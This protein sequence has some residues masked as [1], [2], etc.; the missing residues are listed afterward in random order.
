[1]VVV[2]TLCCANSSRM[3]KSTGSA[4]LGA[5]PASGGFHWKKNPFTGGD[6][7]R[8]A[9]GGR[10]R[11]AE[12]GTGTSPEWPWNTARNGPGT[13]LESARNGPGTSPEPARHSP[14][15]APSAHIT[16]SAA[17]GKENSAVTTRAPGQSYLK[18]S[19]ELFTS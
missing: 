16:P 14:G 17:A 1:M 15:I 18:A 9:G 12:I 13:A 2:P 11:A 19:S 5:F 3:R 8:R 4:C 10:H 6:R 7:N